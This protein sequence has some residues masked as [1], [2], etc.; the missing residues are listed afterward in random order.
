MT[1]TT[2]LDID[3][4]SYQFQ[5]ITIYTPLYKDLW[6]QDI[7]VSMATGY[8]LDGL[9]SISGM[10]RLFSC[11]QR[12][13]PLWGPPSLLSNGYQPQFPQ[14]VKRPGHEADHSHP[15]SAEVK[16]GGVMPPLPNMSS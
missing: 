16:N 14:G 9:G 3:A 12:P 13:D 4:K 10:A 5:T 6:T 11:P 8:G 7:S 2:I 15:S 1:E